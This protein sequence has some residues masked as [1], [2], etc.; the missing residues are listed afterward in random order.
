MQ[1]VGTAH[2]VDSDEFDRVM[3][4]L[5]EI[6]GAEISAIGLTI[7]VVYTPRGEERVLKAASVIADI[8]AIIEKVQ[9]HGLSLLS[10]RK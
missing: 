10:E 1:L 4:E 2:C 7:T 9:T 3:S 6:P 5:S 8:S